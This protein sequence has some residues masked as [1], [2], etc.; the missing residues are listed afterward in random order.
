MNA[1]DTL[2]LDD[3]Q[4]DFE[5]M[6]RVLNGEQS[7]ERVHI[8]EIWVDNEFVD[9]VTRHALGEPFPP[10]PD[11]YGNAAPD[12]DYYRK[13]IYFFY[14]VGFDFALYWPFWIKHPLI[15]SQAAHNT[16][17]LAQQD[18]GWVAEDKGLVNSWEEFDA[19]PWADIQVDLRP[20]DY[21]QK[22]LPAGM[23][24]VICGNFWQQV[25]DRTIGQ[26]FLLYNLYDQ[27][28]LIVSVLD[29]WGE[30]V[31]RYFNTA[32]THDAVGGILLADDLGYTTSTFVA[33]DW[34]RE[35]VLNWHKKF[36][37]AAHE[38]GKPFWL[39]CCGN[40]YRTGL[41][42]DMID[43]VGI[44]GFNSF[45]DTILPVTDFMETYG[46]RIAGLGGVDMDKLVRL[47]EQP[48]R[49]YVRTILDACMPHGRYALG[50]GNSLANYIPIENYAI[51]LDEGRCWRYSSE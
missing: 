33:P 47:D 36:A 2:L 30:L 38:H 40:M 45:Q 11:R 20:L 50:S 12:E 27:E 5:G 8:F 28:D 25:F 39:H 32:I 43:H 42:E 46:S 41:I 3:P 37:D 18:R 13:L 9:M 29:K 44:D 49:E 7:P 35:H 31:L 26:A 48:L 51:M 16:A 22:H 10:L 34:I 19:F 14:H 1:I 21:F 4:P 24:T 23:K 15:H 6:V 17:G